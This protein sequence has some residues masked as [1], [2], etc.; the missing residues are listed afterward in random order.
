MPSDDRRLSVV[1]RPPVGDLV[2][3]GIAV[4]CISAS[5]PMIVATA[6][7]ALAIAFWRCFIGAGATAP[8][9]LWRQRTEVRRLSRRDL[10]YAGAAGL[11]L[12]AHFATWIPSLSFTSVAASTALVSTQPV[13]AAVIGRIRGAYVPVRVWLGIALSFAGILVLVGV[14]FATDPRALIGDGLALVG[15]MLAAA[16]VTVGQAA[17]QTVSTGTYTLL[18][19]GTAAIALLV[20]CIIGGQALTGYSA[21]AW[22]F[23]VLLTVTAQLLGHTLMN[24]VLVT[25][26]A[27]V[28]SLAILFEMPGSTLIAALWLGQVPPWQLIPAVALLLTG[29]VVVIRSARTTP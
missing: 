26:S 29:L 11:L 20:T 17:R 10:G 25:T 4:L 19:Y 12:A 28:V 23:I 2:M 8:W 9:V 18:V 16:Y 3:M 13:W 15:A 24:R 5:G 22:G 1:S 6:A 27:T 21:Q 14:H 7:P